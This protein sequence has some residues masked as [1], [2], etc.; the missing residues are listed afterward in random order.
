MSIKK[1]LKKLIPYSFMNQYSQLR[2]RQQMAAYFR[3]DARRYRQFAT[4]S[5]PAQS[6]EGVRSSLI[7]FTH[8]IEKGLSHENFR[9]NFGK[10]ALM[11]I[12]NNLQS[13]NGQ[14]EDVFEYQNAVSVL[15][16]YKRRHSDL[17]IET[18]YFDTLFSEFSF[19]DASATLAGVNHLHYSDLKLSQDGSTKFHDLVHSRH[20]LRQFS[21]EK[22]DEV[23]IRDAVTEAMT[24]PTVCDRQPSRV[25]ATTNAEKISKLLQIQGGYVGFD[26][27]AAIAVVCTELSDFRGPFERNE[28]YVDGGL[29]L[30]NFLL[31]LTDRHLASCTLNTMLDNTRLHQIRS[32]LRIPDS[33]VL[34][35]YVA[36]GNFKSD[37][38]VTNSARKSAESILKFI[39]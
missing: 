27:P 21:G 16:A 38:T 8:S 31:S 36:I 28:P 25:Y 1:T 9:P 11:G 20:S 26:Q 6:V 33:N 7:F 24:T 3:K 19:T 10:Y 17:N 13:F 34:I 5:N 4:F 23:Q 15:S 39:E 14:D 37:F 22:V 35:A 29:F 30:M 32:L 2:M 12:R 18:P